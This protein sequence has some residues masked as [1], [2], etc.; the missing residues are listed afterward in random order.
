[1][2][3]IAAILFVGWHGFSGAL[4]LAAGESVAS[5]SS[6]A[7]GAP[8]EDSGDPFAALLKNNPA[9]VV[10]TGPSCRFIKV[11]L[12]PGVQPEDIPGF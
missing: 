10:K 6:P 7:P 1:M 4:T 11:Q 5:S 12:P 9:E 3:A 8:E 2:A